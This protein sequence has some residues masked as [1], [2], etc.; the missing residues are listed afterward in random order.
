MNI[1]LFIKSNAFY[2]YIV[3]LSR[4]SVTHGQLRSENIK[5]KVPE[6]KNPYVFKL[7]VV[8]SSMMQSGA[9]LPRT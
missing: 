1:L 7:C 9:V 3:L 5:W 4:I 8:P 6:I 2:K